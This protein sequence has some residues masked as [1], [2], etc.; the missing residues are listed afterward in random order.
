MLAYRGKIGFI[1]P[2]ADT[3]GLDEYFQL[4]PE[5]VHMI[6]STTGVSKLVHEDVRGAV[7]PAASHRIPLLRRTARVQATPGSRLLEDVNILPRNVTV[8]NQ[9]DGSGQ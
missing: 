3:G 5:G 2:A 1:T 9:V 6:V 4:L 8:P 7:H